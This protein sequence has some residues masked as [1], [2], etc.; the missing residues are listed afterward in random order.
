MVATLRVRD[1]L[2]TNRAQ[3]RGYLVGQHLFQAKPK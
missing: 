3:I 1:S 2:R